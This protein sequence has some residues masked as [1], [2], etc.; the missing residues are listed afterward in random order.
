MSYWIL[1]MVMGVH[2]GATSEQVKTP[3]LKE[4]QR[5]AK[6]ISRTKLKN[7]V[8]NMTCVEVRTK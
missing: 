4:C 3:S 6:N 8:W 1:I 5:V 2:Q 7:Y